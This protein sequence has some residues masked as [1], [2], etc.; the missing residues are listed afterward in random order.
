LEKFVANAK[1]AGFLRDVP[2]LSRL[3]EK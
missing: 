1:A 2:D 3:I